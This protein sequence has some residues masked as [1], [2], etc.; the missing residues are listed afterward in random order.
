VPVRIEALFL[1]NSH[2]IEGTPSFRG[3]ITLVIQ[4]GKMRGWTSKRFASSS[5]TCGRMNSMSWKS[6]SKSLMRQ[7]KRA[8]TPEALSSACEP[9]ADA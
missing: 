4:D 1:E 2:E 6:S 5:N 3:R 9:A 7:K 8:A